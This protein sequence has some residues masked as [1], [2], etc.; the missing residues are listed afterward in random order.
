[1]FYVSLDYGHKR[2]VSYCMCQSP[3]NKK[4]KVSWILGFQRY[5]FKF[6]NLNYK[7]HFSL[8]PSNPCPESFRGSTPGILTK[9]PA[10]S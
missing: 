5:V 8:D 3:V 9:V 4:N 2:D 6:H 7:I 10:F 1:M